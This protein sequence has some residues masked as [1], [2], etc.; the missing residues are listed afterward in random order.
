LKNDGMNISINNTMTTIST[1]WFEKDNLFVEMSDGYVIKTPVSLYPN[2]SKGTTE[3]RKKYE[4]KGNGRW[5][6]WE[7]LDEDLS[8]EGFLQKK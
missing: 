2:L 8:A 6:H 1:V 5:V 4:I 7:E 3:Q